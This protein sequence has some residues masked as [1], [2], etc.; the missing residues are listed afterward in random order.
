MKEDN[1]KGNS[2]DK[3][4]ST[5]VAASYDYSHQ[6]NHAAKKISSPN[7]TMDGLCM[8]PRV[9]N[10]PIT[11]IHQLLYCYD[12][13]HLFCGVPVLS[14]LGIN[15]EADFKKILSIEGF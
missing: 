6:S 1:L 12:S 8:K 3:E 15:G 14:T 5:Q 7:L 10:Y 2:F 13:Q 11:P 9:Q 4:K